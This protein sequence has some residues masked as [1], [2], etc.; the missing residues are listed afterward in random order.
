MNMKNHVCPISGGLS[1]CK[2]NV[3]SCACLINGQPKMRH[4]VA[5]IV[6]D[7]VSEANVDQI[8]KFSRQRLFQAPRTIQATEPRTSWI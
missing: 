8:L 1:I 5:Q 7:H 3:P 4:K 2:R 6:A